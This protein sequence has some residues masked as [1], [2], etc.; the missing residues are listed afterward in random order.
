MGRVYGVGVEERE[1]YEGF[2]MAVYTVKINTVLGNDNYPI[3]IF[4]LCRVHFLRTLANLRS[5]NRL[6]FATIQ[7]VIH[8][9]QETF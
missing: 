6:F 3:I 7:L 9:Y 1:N 8:Q 5:T 2:I 4:V